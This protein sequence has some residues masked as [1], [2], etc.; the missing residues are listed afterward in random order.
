MTDAPAAANVSGDLHKPGFM[1]GKKKKK[2]K[3]REPQT[4]YVNRPV[5]NADEIAAWAKSIGI[6]TVVT[7]PHV[8]IAYSKEP[9][10]WPERQVGPLR[11]APKGASVERFGRDKDCLVLTF[12]SQELEERWQDLVDS[13]CSWDWPSYRPHITLSWSGYNGLDLAPAEI[14]PFSGELVLGSE[15]FAPIDENWQDNVV[16]KIEKAIEEIHMSGIEKLG[17]RNSRKDA[18][19]I[20]A[21]H[22]HSVTLGAS[23]DGMEKKA[24]PADV[25]I[26]KIDDSLGLVFGYAIVCKVDGEDYYDLNIDK[27]DDGSFERVP[28]HIPESSMLKAAMDFME[29]A[30]PGNEMHKGD[31]VGSYLFAFPLTTDI[32]K[33]FGIATR[34]T[35]LMVAYKPPAAVFAK[36]KNGTYKGFSI[37]GRRVSAKTQD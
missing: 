16:E 19:T 36:F 4:L 28:E 24:P 9:V 15:E 10:D 6:S 5:L 34:T 25:R 26:A 3:K 13:G 30:R 32:A 20:Q 7:D 27:N 2:V 37:E 33:A 23:C 1:A 8:T 12:D 31:D 29:T 17:A 21:M 22:D 11:I 18:A 14:P 35:G